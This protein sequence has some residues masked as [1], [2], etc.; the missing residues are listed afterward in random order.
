MPHPHARLGAD[1]IERPSPLRP[2]PEM[3]VTPLIDI[4]LVLLVIFM[5]ALPMTQKGTDVDIP[6]EAQRTDGPPPDRQVVIELTADR[7]L[8]VNKRPVALAELTPWLRDIY[9]DRRD[10]TIFLIGDGSLRYGDVVAVI[11][12]AKAAGLEKVGVVTEGMRAS[13]KDPGGRPAPR[14]PGA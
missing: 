9:R 2:R 8:A 12:A 14:T 6:P 11:D 3:N 10:K 7:Q 1:R 13:T 5:A 4:L